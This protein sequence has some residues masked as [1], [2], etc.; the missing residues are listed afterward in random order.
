MS[1][2]P[3]KKPSRS[4]SSQ[5][6]WPKWMWVA[7]PV[8]IVFIVAG[9]WWAVFSPMEPGGRTATPTPTSRLVT[10][11][12][13]KTP[14]EASPPGVLPPTPTLALLPTLPLPTPTTAAPAAPTVAPTTAAPTFSIGAKAVV[15]GTGASGLNVRAGAG[16]G[17][18]RVKTLPDGAVLEIIGGPKEADGYT[19]YQ[20][21]DEVGATGWA[22]VS[23][24]RAQ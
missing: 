6:V 17:H 10:D 4:R 19:W 18:A 8:L 5:D 16:T 13:T 2:D 15:Q 7:A 3:K 14:T 21:R 24:M 23:Y 9:L 12:I 20:V 22:V 1:L 11:P